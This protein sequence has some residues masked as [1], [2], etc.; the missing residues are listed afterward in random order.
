MCGSRQACRWALSPYSTPRTRR[1][2]TALRLR[3]AGP[4]P[5]VLTALYLFNPLLL[6]ASAARVVTVLENFAVVV[7]LAGA[8]AGRPWVAAGG[9]AVAGYL[10][11]HPLLLTVSSHC[12]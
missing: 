4:S 6:L 7:A 9:V 2:H 11:L 3:P 8:C 10:G 12:G 5:N 1:P